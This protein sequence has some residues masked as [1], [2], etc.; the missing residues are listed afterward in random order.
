[1]DHKILSDLLIDAAKL[2]KV[3]EMVSL[4]GEG[5]THPSWLRAVDSKCVAIQHKPVKNAHHLSLSQTIEDAYRC[6]NSPRFEKTILR[7][8]P[9]RSVK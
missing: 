3:A 5:A 9:S 6:E 2:G 1:M 8:L 4:H 7:F